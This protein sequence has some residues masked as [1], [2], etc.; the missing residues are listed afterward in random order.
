MKLKKINLEKN[1]NQVI[2]C[3]FR[4]VSCQNFS[5]SPLFLK[6]DLEIFENWPFDFEKMEYLKQ[7]PIFSLLLKEC[8][9][10]I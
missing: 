4:T 2:M 9:D 3:S 1:P 8:C 7:K 10:E 5:P 6:I